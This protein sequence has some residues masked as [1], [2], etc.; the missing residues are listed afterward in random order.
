M[1]GGLRNYRQR[2]AGNLAVIEKQ[3]FVTRLAS[4]NQILSQMR[5]AASSGLCGMTTWRYDGSVARPAPTV[6]I[7]AR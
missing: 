6:T 3:P 2:Q 1:N 4:G 7:F 5:H